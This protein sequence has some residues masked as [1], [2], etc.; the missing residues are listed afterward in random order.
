MVFD[1]DAC[2]MIFISNK[3]ATDWTPLSLQHLNWN[4]Q[5][6]PGATVTTYGKRFVVNVAML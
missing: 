6:L 4:K 5:R 2:F 1:D 3:S